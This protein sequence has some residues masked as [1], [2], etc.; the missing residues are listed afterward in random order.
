VR[1]PDEDLDDIL[2]AHDIADTALRKEA[3]KVVRKL[4]ERD[5]LKKPGLSE[6]L[7]W[8]GYL[9]AANIEPATLESVPAAQALLKN[10]ADLKV[11]QGASEAV[12]P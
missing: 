7:D 6:L 10:A 5:L 11:V 12:N 4:R 3:I 1:F 9:Q 8:I 2:T